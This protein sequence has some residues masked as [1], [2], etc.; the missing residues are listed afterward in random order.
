MTLNIPIITGPGIDQWNSWLEP[1][2]KL[3]WFEAPFYF[4]ETCFYR[5]ILDKT[6][7]FANKYDPF[8]TQK[9]KDIEDNYE[10][11]INL[12][13]VLDKSIAEECS[14][15]AVIRSLLSMA[16]WGNKSDLSQL[17]LSKTNR[18]NLSNDF[19]IIDDTEPVSDILF[20]G[21]RRLDIILDNSGMELFADLLL[22]AVLIERNLV[23]HA[24]LHAKAYP[25]FVSDATYTD[26][27]VLLNALK[28]HGNKALFNISTMINEFISSGKIFVKDDDFWNAPLHYYQFP[29]K[30]NNYLKDSDLIIFKGDANYR[31]LFGDR[32]IP[33]NRGVANFTNYL[34]ARSVAIRILKSELMFGMDKEQI[35]DLFKSDKDWLVNGKYGIIQSV[36][37]YN[38]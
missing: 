4:V 34:P 15:K 29:K 31:R 5:I 8:A 3:T 7:F 26:I 18:D 19:L 24:V 25:T 1:Y 13:E 17:H 35:T 14:D 11:F 32:E 12:L 21:I 38:I 22:V 23:D 10:Q 33:Y 37:G 6:E 20:K 2:R 9:K 30:L 27:E 36:S 28:L 16:L